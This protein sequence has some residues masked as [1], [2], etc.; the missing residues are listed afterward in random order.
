VDVV[1]AIVTGLVIWLFEYALIL[2]A[3]DAT[4]I[5][6]LVVK[7]AC[8]A[9]PAALLS[10]WK[11]R[12]RVLWSWIAIALFGLVL[13]SVVDEI[14]WRAT[15]TPEQR[16][17]LPEF[18]PFPFEIV[19]WFWQALLIMAVTHFVGRLVLRVTATQQ[20]VEPERR[21]RFSHQA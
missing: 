19:V 8:F 18:S 11:N 9:L 10:L 21:K 7:I 14:I 2:D 16:F 17:F 6:S 5:R 20:I 3:F 15:A 12:I 1:A 13:T 4:A